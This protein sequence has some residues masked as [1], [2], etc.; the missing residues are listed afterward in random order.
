M[1]FTIVA[2]VA[3]LSSTVL[4]QGLLSQIPK[5]AVSEDEIR[6]RMMANCVTAN[7]LRQQSGHLRSG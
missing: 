1:R 6:Q 7:L 5:C 2:T 3:A 4:A